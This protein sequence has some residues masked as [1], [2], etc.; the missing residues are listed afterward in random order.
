MNKKIEFKN[1]DNEGI[2]VVAPTSDQ[3]ILL[4]YFIG[5]YR[6]KGEFEEIIPRL[7]SIRSGQKT[8][9]QVQPSNV[10][11][12]FGNASGYFECDKDTAYLEPLDADSEFQRVVLPLQEV[13]DL[14]REWKRFLENN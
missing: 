7:E 2:T 11:W 9:D 4:A 5:K 8:F 12:S 13:I 3:Y 6:F 10:L 14:F 1:I